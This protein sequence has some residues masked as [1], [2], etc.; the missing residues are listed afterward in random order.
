MVVFGMELRRLDDF[1]LL[2]NLYSPFA[3]TLIESVLYDAKTLTAS[4]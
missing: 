2:D 3:M 4:R 1:G